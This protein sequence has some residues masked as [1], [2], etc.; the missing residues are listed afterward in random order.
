MTAG[1]GL[2]GGLYIPVEEPAAVGE[3][4]DEIE[5]ETEIETG[6]GTGTETEIELKTTAPESERDRAEESVPDSN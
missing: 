4:A 2:K 5:I 6:A 3:S 1:C